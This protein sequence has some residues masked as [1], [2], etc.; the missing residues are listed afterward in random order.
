M[1]AGLPSDDN[2]TGLKLQ[3]EV[4]LAEYK[5][6]R[7]Q[8]AS[9]RQMQGQLDSLALTALGLSIPLILILLERGVEAIGAI[10]LLP[11]LFFAIAFTQL[12]H[13]RQINLDSIFVDSSIRPKANKVLSQVSASEVSVFEYEGFLSGHYFPPN[14]FVQWMVTTSRGGISIG[15]GIGLVAICLYLQLV[16]FKLEWNAYETWLLLIALLV[17]VADLVLGF[18]IARMHYSF[19]TKQHGS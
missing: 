10:L 6:L 1:Q 5:M 17:L 4:L 14:L 19:Y 18:Y 13:E 9:F 11:I 15:I 3:F 12:R 8:V 7:D 16:L 2:H